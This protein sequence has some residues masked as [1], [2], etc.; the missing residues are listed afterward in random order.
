MSPEDIIIWNRAKYILLEGAISVYYD[1][2]LGGQTNVPPGTPP[3]QAMMWQRVTQ[4]RIDVVIE[5]NIFWKIIELRHNA[6][7]SAIGRLLM[8]NQMWKQDPPDSKDVFLYLVT[9]YPDKD[10]SDAARTLNIMY[11]VY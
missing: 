3:A 10:V 6:S 9:D 4:K 11:L 1:V 8:Y 5:T 2:G 7:A